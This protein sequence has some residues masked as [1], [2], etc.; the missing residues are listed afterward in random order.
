MVHPVHRLEPQV[1]FDYTI[2]K[3][4]ML[5]TKDV[6]KPQ[7]TNYCR[8]PL[9]CEKCST[10]KMLGGEIFLMTIKGEIFSKYSQAPFPTTNLTEIT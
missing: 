7:T 10:Q 5:R 1:F 9:F 8:Q 3:Q 2:F 6:R 4:K